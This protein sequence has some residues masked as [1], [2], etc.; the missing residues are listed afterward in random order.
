M[1][2]KIRL[3]LHST[4][5]VS[6]VVK[7]LP[8]R[9]ADSFRFAAPVE[10]ERERERKGEKEREREKRER[11]REKERRHQPPFFIPYRDIL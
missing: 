10:K 7:Y 3:Q 5:H 6:G 2:A 1:F 8:L 9:S 11:K 4:V